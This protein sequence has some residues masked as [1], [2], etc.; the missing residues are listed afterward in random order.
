LQAPAAPWPE[1]GDHGPQDAGRTKE[2]AM[3]LI[4]FDRDGRVSPGLWLGDTVLD[5][6]LASQL[7]G[8][9][10]ITSILAVVQ[11]G[12]KAMEIVAKLAADAPA[13]AIYKAGE[14]K[15]LAPIPVPPRNVVCVGRNYLEHIAEFDKSG[16]EVKPPEWP[17]FF[18]KMPQAV[19]GP[20][21]EVPYFSKIT[22]AM[23]YEV[24]LGVII[25]KGGLNIDKADA[26]D[27]VFGYTIGNDITARDLQQRHG[28]WFKGKSLDRSCPMGPWIVTADELGDPQTL[29]ISL[30][31]NG[32]TRQHSNTKMM[33]FDV[34]SI[35]AHLSAGL[36]LIPGDIIIT[37]TPSGVGNAM[38]PKGLMKG[39]D[40]VT[41]TISRIGSLTS[42]IV[43]V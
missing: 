42:H 22:K 8:E 16:G 38:D 12:D 34:A 26:L 3:K 13:D 39:G 4:T 27:H 10:E 20:D 15:L 21:A 1:S 36:T 41:C 18:T 30:T 28:Q 23:D 17:Q 5:L 11:G 14:V 31:L 7:A 32:E 37:G 19:V 2:A 29:D 43:E 40:T 35:I 33:I 6:G 9:T 25:G 24:E